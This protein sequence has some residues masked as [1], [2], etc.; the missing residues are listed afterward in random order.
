MADGMELHIVKG[1]EERIALVLSPQLRYVG[2][3]PD[4]H[5]V[6]EENTVSSRHAVF[7]IERGRGYVRDLNSRNGTYKNGDRVRGSAELSDGDIVTLGRTI[8]FVVRGE[9]RKSSAAPA[10]H[11]L[12][13][14]E[15][16]VKYPFWDNRFYIGSGARADLR[17]D[18]DPED[19]VAIQIH[20]D[21]DIWVTRMDDEGPIELF[22]EL[23][24]AGRR[25]RVV[26]GTDA[27]SIK[28]TVTR[29]IEPNRFQYQLRVTL[30]GVAGPE[31]TIEDPES[32]RTHT[33]DAENRA[34]LL[35]ILAKKAVEARDAG[36]FD[37]E[38]W[39]A[40]DDVSTGVWGKRGTSDANSLHVLV[41]RLRKELRKAGFEPWFI[42]KRRKAIRIAL[43]TVTVH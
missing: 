12:E 29:E 36:R 2:R 14:I 38:S 33:V 26:E 34:I 22:G 13:D 21:G 35:Y 40:D 28:D 15:T 32:N 30:D 8:K 5:L 9:P 11:A 39:C 18:L 20:E 41:H 19:E 1:G 23:A 4:N 6:L 3:T 42:E 43:D 31:A 25:F 17:L 37:E 7:W 27:G 16:G 24:V 10:Y